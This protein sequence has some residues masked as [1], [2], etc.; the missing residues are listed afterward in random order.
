M[1]Q[2]I[3]CCDHPPHPHPPS[4]SPTAAHCEIPQ[5]QNL[6]LENVQVQMT[7]SWCV[8]LVSDLYT[9]TRSLWVSF[10]V[11]LL[12]FCLFCGVCVH[13]IVDVTVSRGIWENNAVHLGGC[14]LFVLVKSVRNSITLLSCRF[15]IT[16]VHA[17]LLIHAGSLHTF[18]LCSSPA[19]GSP[20][21]L[22]AG[23]VRF[24]QWRRENSCCDK[25]YK[26][27]RLSLNRFSV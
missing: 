13:S 17:L 4:V 3:P 6:V 18:C 8:V 26:N 24:N 19:P 22:D 11:C 7:W 5:K 15:N 23:N 27:P 9:V 1:M 16:K 2:I 21:V 25:K 12:L 10:P 20:S 14:G